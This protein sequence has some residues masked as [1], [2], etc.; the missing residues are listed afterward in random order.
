[1]A[2]DLTAVTYTKAD[3]GYTVATGHLAV[4]YTGRSIDFTRGKATNAAV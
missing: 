4:V 1:M 3:P 2:R